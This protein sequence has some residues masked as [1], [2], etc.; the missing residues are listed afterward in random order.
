MP[1]ILACPGSGKSHFCK[2]S[3]IWQDQ[4]NVMR[5]LHKAEWATRQHT[6]AEEKEHYQRLDKE[7]AKKT[8]THF[9]IGSL[10]W[11]F[12]PDAIVVIPD[13][14][15]RE[16]VA[17]RPADGPEAL[18]Y[19]AAKRVEADLKAKARKHKVPVFDTFAAASRHVLFTY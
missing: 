13:K 12:I 16:R 9:I 6:K 2:R 17:K 10:Y 4:Q 15:L 5:T 14:L 1:V 19:T 7:L 8:K 18:T 11:D 3:K